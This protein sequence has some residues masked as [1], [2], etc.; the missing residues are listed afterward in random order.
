MNHPAA[1]IEVD[2]WMPPVAATRVERRRD[3]GWRR[4]L[5]CGAVAALHVVVALLLVPRP[6]QRGASTA[7]SQPAMTATLLSI[8][9][10][11]PEIA[12]NE[13]DAG[14]SPET[15]FELPAPPRLP[16]PFEEKLEEAPETPVQAFVPPRLDEKS[17]LDMADF[18]RRAGID[19]G[20]S[21]RVILAVTVNEQ[22]VAAD[23]RVAISSGDSLVD[24][25]A[26]EYARALRWDPAIVQ[27]R[28]SS[29]NIRLPVVLAA[30]R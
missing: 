21:A 28:N 15:R 26:V 6:W 8:E 10:A 3:A 12:A 2:I 18:A 1:K 29:M 11:R 13:A 4:V 17:R 14:A 30:P 22:G 19:P 20:R 24:A 16:E 5:S 9:S 27:G 7:E 23:I 25:L